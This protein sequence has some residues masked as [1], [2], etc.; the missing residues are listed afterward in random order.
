M[1]IDHEIKEENG[2]EDAIVITSRE[3]KCD[4]KERYKVQAHGV[5]LDGYRAYYKE[6]ERLERMKQF[7]EVLSY[8]K[9][10]K[11]VDKVFFPRCLHKVYD[12]KGWL[13]VY[14]VMEP[15]EFKEIADTIAHIWEHIFN[16]NPEA[17][18]HY[19]PKFVKTI[20]KEEPDCV[21][22]DSWM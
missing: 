3:D 12:D 13:R 1:K 8:T 11:L 9:H 17:I 7:V 19:L 22:L 10:A 18:T 16:E 6:T 20:P 15:I 4:E 2:H 21:G 14:W 5:V